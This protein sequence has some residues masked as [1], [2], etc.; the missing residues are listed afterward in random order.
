VLLQGK[1]VWDASH[2]KVKANAVQEAVKNANGSGQ[3]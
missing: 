3:E 2:W 1:V